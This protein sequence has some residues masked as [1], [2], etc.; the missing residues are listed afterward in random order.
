MSLCTLNYSHWLPGRA[1]IYELQEMLSMNISTNACRF[2]R[3]L[4]FSWGNNIES[5]KSCALLV[6]WPCRQGLYY[7]F[8]T[9]KGLKS[10]YCTVLCYWETTQ[11]KFTILS[12]FKWAEIPVTNLYLKYPRKQG[13]LRGLWVYSWKTI[14]SQTNLLPETAFSEML[15]LLLLHIKRLEKKNLPPCFPYSIVCTQF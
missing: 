3:Y 8:I 4:G 2:C 15:I 14:T 11:F 12:D 7:W 6:E 10:K 1:A 5:T 9:V 13:Y